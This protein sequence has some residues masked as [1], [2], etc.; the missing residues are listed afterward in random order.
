M[1]EEKR[2]ASRLHCL[3]RGFMPTIR[4]ILFPFDFSEQGLQAAPFVRAI[5]SRYSAKLSVMTVVPPAWNT[6]PGGRLPLAGL[7]APEHELRARQDQLLAEQFA[8][9]TACRLTA[10]GDPALKIIEF[11]HDK[12]VDLIMMPTHG[13]SGF[14]NMLLGSV[15]VQ[16]LHEAKCPV[17]T[18]THAEKQ[19]S[20]IKPSKILSAVD[21]SP[22]TGE[23]M[24]WAS[25]FSQQMGAELSFLHVVSSTGD[26]PALAS[27]REDV[28]DRLEAVKQSIL[29]QEPLHVEAGGIAETVTEKA[30]QGRTDLVLI[31]RGLLSSPLGRLRSNAYAIIQQSPC[32]VLSV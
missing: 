20:S 27:V 6:P 30:R 13:V 29:V 7:D 2:L 5:A 26:V 17:W 28:L 11:A 32:P 8:G 16:V 19:P 31:G 21:D 14:R 25:E 1:I 24:R 3:R 22:R 4:H 15:T 12:G 9:L 10:L 23:L 18:A